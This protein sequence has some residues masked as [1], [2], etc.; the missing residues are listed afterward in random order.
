ME[1]SV[2]S[3]SIGRGSVIFNPID[4]LGTI[5]PVRRAKLRG[6]LFLLILGPKSY[7]VRAHKPHISPRNGWVQFWAM[8]W[9]S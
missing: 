2:D 1:L 6:A 9:V 7:L 4:Q 3:L 8:L 5:Q